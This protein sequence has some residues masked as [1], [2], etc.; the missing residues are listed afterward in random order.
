MPEREGS[1]SG[2]R[3]RQMRHGTANV[4]YS[5]WLWR[6]HQSQ[7]SSRWLVWGT[8]DF[9]TRVWPLQLQRPYPAYRDFSATNKRDT[10]KRPSHTAA[11]GAKAAAPGTVHC[12]LTAKGHSHTP[13]PASCSFHSPS[14]TYHYVDTVIAN[15]TT[16]TAK[17][18]S[19][20]MAIH[21]VH[22][23]RSVG[24]FLF[25]SIC[26]MLSLPNHRQ[27]PMNLLTGWNH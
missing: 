12:H 27:L 6:I 22:I 4:V 2:T 24:E 25:P 9:I 26:S 16:T 5:A 10:C 18:H 21:T 14:A 20:H 3:K 23:M 1:K 13:A 8:A 19:S 7:I 17:R 11:A 15:M